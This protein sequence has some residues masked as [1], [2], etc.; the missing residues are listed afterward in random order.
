M[1]YATVDK[2]DDKENCNAVVSGTGRAFVALRLCSR[3]GFHA[4]V[5]ESRGST[6][7]FC[8]GLPSSLALLIC[9]LDIERLLS[10]VCSLPE[11]KTGNDIGTQFVFIGV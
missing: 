9:A 3:Y 6:L 8:C 1:S 7:R 11:V 5:S 10:T 4:H 2:F